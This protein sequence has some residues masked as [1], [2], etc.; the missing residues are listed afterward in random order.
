MSLSL[1]SRIRLN[2]GRE[3][4]VLGL[5]MWNLSPGREAEAAVAHALRV[6]YRHFDTAKLYGNERDLGAAILGNDVPRDQIFVT[7][8][9]WNDDHGRD[10]AARAFD[11]SLATLG[12]EYVDLYLIH[13]PEGGQRSE[14][15]RALQEIAQGGRARSIGVS[16]YA[17]RHLEEVLAESEVVPAVDQVEFHPFLYRRELLDFCTRHGI[18]VE[19]YSPLTK[20]RRLHDPTVQEVAAKVRRTPAQV[21][22]RWSLQHGLV[23]I[24]KS[25]RPERIE[26][27][28]RVF[29]FSLSPADMARLDGLDEGGHGSWNPNR[30]P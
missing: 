21:L 19:A 16:N 20:G 7:T 15:W 27:N 22:I 29:D 25:S 30:I 3:M 24:P 9:L 26:E 1:S 12:L 2:D 23:V 17:I 4:P 8:K 13:W 11:Q 18:V 10:R 14:S 28:A 6:G 5:G